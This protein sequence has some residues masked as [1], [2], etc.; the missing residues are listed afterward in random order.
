MQEASPCRYPPV[1]RKKWPLS[2]VKA[3]FTQPF[4]DLLFQVQTAHRA[5]FDANRV[6]VSTLL[7]IK[8]GACLED[9]R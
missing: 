5:R 1:V 6:Q 9:C 4:N 8:T 2:E 3:L 7:S